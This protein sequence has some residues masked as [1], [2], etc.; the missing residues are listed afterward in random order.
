MIGKTLEA[1]VAGIIDTQGHASGF[2]LVHHGNPLRFP[3]RNGLR[4]QT[5]FG[6]KW[7]V[8]SD[9]RARLHGSDECIAQAHIRLVFA[10]NDDI[11]RD[12]DLPI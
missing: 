5:F 4:I 12:V 10:G 1:Q 3:I 8:G 9:D 7:T 6:G 2:P 11:G